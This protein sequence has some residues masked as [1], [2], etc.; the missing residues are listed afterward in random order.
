MSAATPAS[1]QPQAAAPVPVQPQAAPTAP[2][3][4]VSGLWWLLSFFLLLPGGLVAWAVV[5]RDNPRKAIQL[6][7]FSLFITVFIIYAIVQNLD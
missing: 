7:A 4:S 3:K 1:V 2:V 5:K 6:L